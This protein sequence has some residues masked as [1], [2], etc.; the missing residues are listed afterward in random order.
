MRSGLHDFFDWLLRRD[1]IEKAPR[2][3]EVR[4]KLSYRQTLGKETKQAI[5]AEI[6]R[7]AP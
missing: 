7:I 5:L 1:I 4:V 2:F 3:P 6:A